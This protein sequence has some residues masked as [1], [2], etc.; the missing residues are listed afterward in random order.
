[1]LTIYCLTGTYLQSVKSLCHRFRYSRSVLP[2][3]SLCLLTSRPSFSVKKLAVAFFVLSVAAL[4]PSLWCCA[5]V[6]PSCQ[7][8]VQFTPRESSVEVGTRLV[9]RQ[10]PDGTYYPGDAFDFG[11]LVSW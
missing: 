8:S 10:N 5:Y 11:V 4:F 1:M 9:P 3:G 2:T 7:V 6:D